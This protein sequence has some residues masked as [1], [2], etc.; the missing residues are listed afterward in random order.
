MSKTFRI[1]ALSAAAAIGLTAAVH[2]ASAAD[3]T[4]EGYGIPAETKHKAARPAPHRDCCGEPYRFVYAESWYGQNKVI[5]PVRHGELGD[6]V[7]LPGGTWVYCEWSCEYTLRKQSMDYWDAVTRQKQREA[8]QYSRK[9]FYI[10]RFGN[11]R[12]Y[13]F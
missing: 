10:D 2:D 4:E 8:P 12:D 7:R 6:Q 9:D 11:R 1:F 3:K 13:L 5:A